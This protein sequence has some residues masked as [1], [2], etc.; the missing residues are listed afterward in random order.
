MSNDANEKRKN[1]RFTEKKAKYTF[2]NTLVSGLIKTNKDCLFASK[3]DIF[4][5]MFYCVQVLDTTNQ[6]ASVF[7]DI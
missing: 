3:C 7:R 2:V 6:E 5:S 1:A 4:H